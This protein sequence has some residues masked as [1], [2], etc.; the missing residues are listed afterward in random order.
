MPK[1]VQVRLYSGAQYVLCGFQHCEAP[2]AKQKS[3]LCKSVGWQAGG[4]LC[5]TRF[6]FGKVFFR[7]CLNCFLPPFV[8]LL[9]KTLNASLVFSVR[10]HSW[11]ASFPHFVHSIHC[12]ALS[13]EGPTDWMDAAYWIC[14]FVTWRRLLV[15]I[16]FQ[17]YWQWYSL[18]KV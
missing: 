8:K 1:L 3:F 17:K 4:L 14:S 7:I 6:A 16:V 9:S 2:D 15:L 18:P 5:V 11:G 13:T 10:S 12:H